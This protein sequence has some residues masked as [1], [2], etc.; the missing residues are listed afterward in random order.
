MAEYSEYESNRIRC[1]DK[2]PD[3]LVKK[4]QKW[5]IPPRCKSTLTPPSSTPV[6]FDGYNNIKM[7]VPDK[8]RYL[9]PVLIDKLKK[10]SQRYTDSF[11]ITSAD[12]FQTGGGACCTQHFVCKAVD[13]VPTSRTKKNI[14]KLAAE[15]SLLGFGGIGIYDNEDGISLHID[16]RD[17]ISIWGNGFTSSGIPSW[18]TKT[19]YAHRDSKITEKNKEVVASVVT[20]DEPIEKNKK[21]VD[22]KEK[23]TIK[24]IQPKKPKLK[25][26]IIDPPE[27]ML[28]LNKELEKDNVFGLTPYLKKKII[29]RFKELI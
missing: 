15:A 25:P 26:S 5:W 27:S 29:D 2:I 17:T 22:K 14:L 11:T 7:G 4:G 8:K 23:Q 19:L 6:K 18:A 10:L 12:R 1:N 21:P 13:I 3:E 24:V 20:S 9:D 28:R 16:V